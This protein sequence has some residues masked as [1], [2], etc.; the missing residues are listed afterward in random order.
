MQMSAALT[1]SRALLS[2]EAIIADG[3]DRFKRERYADRKEPV[4][5]EIA[6]LDL[7]GAADLAASRGLR[8]QPR[9]GRQEWLEYSLD[10]SLT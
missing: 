1:P 6:A 5:H 2:A 10:R 7:A 9:S 4:G 3:L 8:P